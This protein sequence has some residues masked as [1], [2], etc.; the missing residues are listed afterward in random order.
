MTWDAYRIFVIRTN[1]SKLGDSDPPRKFENNPANRGPRS[2]NLKIRW[3]TLQALFQ[4][5]GCVE[6]EPLCQGFN[7]DTTH[8]VITIQDDP[9]QTQDHPRPLTDKHRSRQ[10]RPDEIWRNLTN[11][12]ETWRDVTRRDQC[13][14]I[15]GIMQTT[16]S[17]EK[18]RKLRLNL[19]EGPKDWCTNVTPFALKH[20]DTISMRLW[21]VGRKCRRCYAQL[22]CIEGS[23]EILVTTR[24]N[25]GRRVLGGQLDQ[26]SRLKN[27]DHTCLTPGTIN[28]S[29]RGL[30]EEECRKKF[31]CISFTLEIHFLE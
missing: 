11:D 19:L 5:D 6:M 29:M 18:A 24:A 20:P 21:S 22:M 27:A 30:S 16:V 17:C 26:R 8:L 2:I 4:I 13:R 9:R 31:L 14:T 12:D 7:E 25:S 28:E 1:S 3:P 15:L 10:T 23:Q